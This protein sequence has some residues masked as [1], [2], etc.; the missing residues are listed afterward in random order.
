MVFVSDHGESLGEHDYWGHGRNLFDHGLLIPLSLTY[1]SRLAPGVQRAPASIGDIAP[2]VM[3]LLGFAVPSFF[4]GL[5]WSSILLDERPGP[6]D[7]EMYFEAHKGAVRPY[8]GKEALRQKGLLEIGRLQ[9]GRK[10]LFRLK[11]AARSVFDLA[12]DP[13]ELESLVATDS[14]TSAELGA[15][16]RAVEKGL[17]LSDDLPPPSLSDEDT[18]ALRALGYL[19]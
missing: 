12:E 13:G 16:L 17:V 9:G 19:D 6:I 1:E 7:R 10:E 18:E 8:E 11:G 5:D 2:T 4:Q 14:D 3:G 15:W